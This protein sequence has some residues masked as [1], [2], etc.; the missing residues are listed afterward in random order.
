MSIAD[1]SILDLVLMDLHMS[2][3]DGYTATQHIRQRESNDALPCAPVI[4]L[5]AN[6][7]EEDRQK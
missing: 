6:A 1:A 3:M 7:C 5:T 4:A 2:V